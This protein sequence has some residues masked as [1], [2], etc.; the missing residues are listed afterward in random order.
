[1]KALAGEKTEPSA[2]VSDLQSL[3]EELR[4]GEHAAFEKVYHLTFSRLY[5]YGCKIT[6]DDVVEEVVQELFIHIW[7]NRDKLPQV[8]HPMAYLFRSFRNSLFNHLGKKKKHP[9]ISLYQ[10][11]E[12]SY[13]PS[14]E[15][16]RTSQARTIQKAIDKL[17]NQQREV[18]Y[19]LYFNDL[20]AP[21]VA[22]VL[23]L[24]VR[25]VYNTAHNAIATLRGRLSKE[26][27][28]L[29]LIPVLLL[30]FFSL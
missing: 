13:Q 3:W 10:L 4:S 8:A 29:Y 7:N 6:S 22:E 30:Y 16:Q 15:A 27:L 28:L 19:L 5:Q 20:S 26:S 1:M 11:P 9:T 21:E 12:F 14:Y 23:S 17:S 25:T 2:D 18:I 24:K